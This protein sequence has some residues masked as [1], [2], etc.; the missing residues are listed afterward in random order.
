[1]II[2]AGMI[3]GRSQGENGLREQ[4]R[5][6]TGGRESGLLFQGFCYKDKIAD[7]FYTQSSILNLVS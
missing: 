2:L 6:D 3:E 5:L 4:K 7:N 1:M